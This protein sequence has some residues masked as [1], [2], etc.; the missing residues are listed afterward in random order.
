[1]CMYGILETENPND[2]TKANEA[3]EA[4]ERLAFMIEVMCFKKPPYDEIKFKE[5]YSKFKYGGKD[6]VNI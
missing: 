4:K 2:E 6:N 3:N 5:P 1:M